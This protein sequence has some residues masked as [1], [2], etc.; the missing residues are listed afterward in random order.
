MGGEKEEVVV[1]DDDDEVV[2]GAAAVEVE[3]RIWAMI[4]MTSLQKSTAFH[5]AAAAALLHCHSLG[6]SSW[7]LDYMTSWD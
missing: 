5:S 3:M 6:H 2:A 1:V 4:S 7:R